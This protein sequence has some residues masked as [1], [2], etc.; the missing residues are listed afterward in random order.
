MTWAYRPARPEV[1][2]S[3]FSMTPSNPGTV[4]RFSFKSIDIDSVY[5]TILKMSKVTSDSNHGI[6]PGAEN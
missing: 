2:S 3:P 4:T 5:F 6:S 1:T